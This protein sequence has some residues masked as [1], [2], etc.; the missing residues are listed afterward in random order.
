M[1]VPKKA[2]KF[3]KAL[4]ELER[5]VARLEKG[6]LPL[7][8]SLQCFEQGIKSARECRAYLE[9]A[10][11]R[12]EI[13]LGKAAGELKLEPYDAGETEDETEDHDD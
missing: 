11:K 10:E 9:E 13:L 6:N 7:E 8:E 3:E 1:P 12:V 4:E 2:V 5:I